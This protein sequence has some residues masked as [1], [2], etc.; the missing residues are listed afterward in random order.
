MNSRRALDCRDPT[1]R[2]GGRVLDGETYRKHA[3]HLMLAA[4]EACDPL[5]SIAIDYLALARDIELAAAA[6]DE[7]ERALKALLTETQDTIN[8]TRAL[9]AKIDEMLARRL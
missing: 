5:L 2:R 8:E 3:A 7:E 4:G 9:I 1:S 6:S